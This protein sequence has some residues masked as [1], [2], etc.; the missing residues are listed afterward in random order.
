VLG[1]YV[2]ERHLLTLEKA[3]HK[4]TGLTAQRFGL[5]D[6]GLIAQGMVADLVV[7]DPATI[8]DTNDFNHPHQYA[9]GIEHLFI[10][11]VQVIAEGKLT[12]EHA[13]SVL[14]RPM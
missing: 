1:K 9:K 8:G 4:M 11:G 6:R 13:G 2:R 7:F 5:K 10:H 14:Y 3:I 12:G